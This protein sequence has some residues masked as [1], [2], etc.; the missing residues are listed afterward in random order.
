MGV[1]TVSHYI[2]W[3]ILPLE[4]SDMPPRNIQ[5]GRK[6]E[7][8]VSH[9]WF[10]RRFVCVI[11]NLSKEKEGGGKW[12]QPEIVLLQLRAENLPAFA[13]KPYDDCLLPTPLY[14]IF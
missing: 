13:Q 1:K 5:N 4:I 10:F 14:A 3:P 11:I 9:N 2:F 8:A 6:E 7:I 12:Q